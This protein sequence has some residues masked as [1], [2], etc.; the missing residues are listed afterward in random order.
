MNWLKRKWK[1]GMNRAEHFL[2]FHI[3][4]LWHF[5]N[6]TDFL[7][8][9]AQENLRLLKEMEIQSNR[10]SF[11]SSLLSDLSQIIWRTND[12]MCWLLKS[13]RC[14]VFSIFT[15][16]QSLFCDFSPSRKF[17]HRKYAMESVGV[18][19]EGW[20][21]KNNNE[22][23]ITVMAFGL[24]IIIIIDFNSTTSS[25]NK[26]IIHLLLYCV[27]VLFQYNMRL[28]VGIF[29]RPSTHFYMRS[30]CSSSIPFFAGQ[31]ISCCCFLCVQVEE[32]ETEATTNVHI[33]K[34]LTV[35]H[36]ESNATREKKR[37]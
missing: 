3:N 12:L 4:S 31:V 15:A 29:F 18:N 28:A 14:S 17:W 13:V 36:T 37:I 24:I 26:I 2:I 9:D 35:M 19:D 16:P 10:K 34:Q 22:E 27:R 25:S 5:N 11:D 6:V 7:N 23:I 21:G 20:G 1:Y 30:L 32:N 8:T 33:S